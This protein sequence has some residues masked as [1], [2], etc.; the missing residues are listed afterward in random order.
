MIPKDALVEVHVGARRA[1]PDRH[2]PGAPC[3]RRHLGASRFKSY[4][5]G[6]EKWQG[7][8]LDCVWFDEEPPLDIYS[9]GLT[10]TNATAGTGVHD[11]HAAARHVARW[12]GASSLETSPDAHV[13]IM[14]IDDAEHYTPS[15]A[16]GASSPAIPRTSARR[17]SRACRCSARAASSRWR[18]RASPSTRLDHPASI[19]R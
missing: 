9:E 15:A 17:A 10:R 12:C 7:E 16:R 13:T 5:K 8:T 2:H 11:L 19:G 14:T 3:R 1:G 18:R 4:E 6:R